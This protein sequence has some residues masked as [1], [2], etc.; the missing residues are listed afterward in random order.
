M[1]KQFIDRV[2]ETLVLGVLEEYRVPGVEH[3]FSEGHVCLEHYGRALA[4]YQRLCDRL[5][6]LEVDDD[7]EEIF[8]AFFSIRDEIGYRMYRYGAQFG[9]NGERFTGVLPRIPTE[10]E[11]LEAL[12]RGDRP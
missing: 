8:D 1:E 7:V 6:V 3:V 5:G 12:M 4:A 9:L 2:Y 10:N 11:I